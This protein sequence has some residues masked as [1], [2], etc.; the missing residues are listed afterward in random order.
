M[1]SPN[2]K[3]P[4]W[5]K[6]PAPNVP[7]NRPFCARLHVTN[8]FTSRAGTLAGFTTSMKLEVTT[9]LTGAKSFFGSYGSLL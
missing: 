4:K 9:W 1:A 6:V 8:C 5:P 7:M 3:A 2:R